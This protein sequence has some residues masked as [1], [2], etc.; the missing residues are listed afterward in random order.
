MPIPV[1][2][3]SL[4]TPLTAEAN[5]APLQQDL[6]DAGF[7][8][9]SWSSTSVQQ[10][11]L[12]LQGSMLTRFQVAQRLVAENA[13]LDVATG[14][15]LTVHAEEVYDTPREA[16]LFTVGFVRLTDTANAGPYTF[17]ATSTSFSV[18]PG[19]LLYSGLYA[20]AT[21]STQVTL[22]KGGTVDV[23]VQS[24][25]IGS[26]YA[27]TPANS[28]TFWARGIIPGVAVTNPTTWLTAYSGLQQG[29]D[30]ETDPHLQDRDRSKWGTLSTGSV[31]KAYRYWALTSSQ[32]VKKVEVYSNYYM[33]DP[34]RV[35]V[36]IA[37][38]TSA[39]GADVVAAVQDYIAP[40]QVGGDR[41]PVT[42]R[43]V[44]STALVQVVTITATLFVQ[45]AYN[46]AA[47]QQTIEAGAGSYFAD[48]SI[49]ALVSR[50]RIIEV[51]LYP[52]GVGA[53]VIVDA[54]VSLPSGDVQLDFNEVAS[55]TLNLT[56]TSV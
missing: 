21:G 27:T 38:A 54:T 1:T 11:L 35:D 41:I 20:A 16:G 42:A 56:M 14:D 4:R 33:F 3:A 22:P 9:L 15:S 18:G 2:Y 48:L 49:G 36:I 40:S 12:N 39:V 51:L 31:E 34:G 32:Q 30:A 47:L 7:G 13:L 46:T 17:S 25:A 26:D 5:T 45:S 37:G 19:G 28:I 52:A 53:G 55:A 6:A 44:V 8:S 29:T 43:A 10:R 23:V 24:A 50:E